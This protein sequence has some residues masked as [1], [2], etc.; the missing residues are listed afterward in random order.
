V[1]VR[2]LQLG[3]FQRIALSLAVM[4]S[5]Q[6]DAGADQPGD[7]I[8]VGSIERGKKEAKAAPLHD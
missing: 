6:V 2:H 4:V 3:T 5:G 7:G 1:P 8:F